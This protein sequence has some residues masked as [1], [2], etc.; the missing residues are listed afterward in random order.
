MGL[1]E[2]VFPPVLQIWYVEV[3]ISRSISE[4]PLEFKITRVDCM[5]S[6]MR[7][8]VLGHMLTAKPRSARKGEQMPRWYF[9]HVQDNLN[10]ILRTVKTTFLFDAANMKSVT[11]LLPWLPLNLTHRSSMRSIFSLAIQDLSSWDPARMPLRT[12]L[13]LTENLLEIY[14]PVIKL[15]FSRAGILWPSQHY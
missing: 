2:L 1:I 8:H 5:C 12:L 10:H 4:S 3:R 6:T 13:M 14:K 15:K 11:V 7:K 9:A